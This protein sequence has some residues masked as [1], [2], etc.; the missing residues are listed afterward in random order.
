MNRREQVAYWGGA[1]LIALFSSAIIVNTT[2]LQPE[3]FRDGNGIIISSRS[4]TS[5]DGRQPPRALPVA[6][7]HVR[8]QVPQ[9]RPMADAR[10]QR[11]A[12]IGHAAT[13]PASQLIAQVQRKLAKMGYNPG[14]VDGRLG[15]AT[16]RALKQFQRA[17]N[18]PATG[19]LEPGVLA[20]LLP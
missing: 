20:V 8:V 16:R 5:G 3:V 18:M 11:T 19:E 1:V 4:M 17:N 10:V 13:R 2:L 7:T 6:A 9:Q 14:P 12:S 15:P